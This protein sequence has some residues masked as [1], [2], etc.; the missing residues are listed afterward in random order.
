MGIP[1]DKRLDTIVDASEPER[2]NFFTG[3][4]F[5]YNEPAYPESTD[6]HAGLA[7]Y[8]GALR[9]DFSDP[10]NSAH[11]A[12]QEDL[13]AADN[14]VR[15][16]LE[17]HAKGDFHLAGQHLDAAALRIESADRKGNAG[18]PAMMGVDPVHAVV[19]DYKR[20]YKA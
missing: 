2:P 4:W 6:H 18:D 11:M 13:R 5:G 9:N 1:T 19:A 16:S 10:T 8:I 7:Q 12:A 20:N 14:S 15:A 3:N 17:A